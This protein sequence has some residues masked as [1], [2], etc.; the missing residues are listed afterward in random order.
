MHNCPVD[1]GRRY[2]P[3]CSQVLDKFLEENLPE[4]FHLQKGAPDDQK[5]KKLRF[6]ELKENVRNAFNKDKVGL[7][8][9]S[10]SSP[11]GEGNHQ[12][13]VTN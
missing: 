11:T 9:S 3:H 12:M 10:S 8:S 1:L 5:T 7:S 6:C 13:P 4:P 2:F